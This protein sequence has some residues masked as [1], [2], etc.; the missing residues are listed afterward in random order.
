MKC[1][2]SPLLFCLTCLQVTPKNH[3]KLIFSEAQYHFCANRDNVEHNLSHKTTQ[4]I[5][6]WLKSLL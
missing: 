6:Q 4:L 5:I 2:V 3:S 1:Y